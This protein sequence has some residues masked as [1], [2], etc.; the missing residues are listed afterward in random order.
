MP[1]WSNQILNR[2]VAPEIIDFVSAEITDLRPEFPEW[3][4]WIANHFLNNVLRGGFHEPWRQYAVNFIRRAQAT[5]QFYHEGRKLTLNYLRDNDPRN[6]KVSLYYQSVATWEAAL[7]NWA[8]C[9]DLVRN[10]NNRDLFQKNDG[11]SEQRAYSL[12][13]TIKHHARD[14]HN[15]TLAGETCL[16]SGLQSLGYIR[17]LTSLLIL[18]SLTLCVMLPGFLRSC[19]TC[20]PSLLRAAPR[21]H[22]KHR[23]VPIG[24]SISISSCGGA[25]GLSANLS[26]Q[27]SSSTRLLF[28][29]T[30]RKRP[31]GSDSNCKSRILVSNHVYS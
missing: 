15:G 20:V 31:N 5:F 29:A 12:H 16:R 17:N 9:L 28:A 14:I 2:Y 26:V 24:A 10:L 22:L 7:L 11:S 3:H 18:S 4:D 27:F 21:R 8:I 23:V 13:N 1:R 30:S 6:P 19:R 25:G